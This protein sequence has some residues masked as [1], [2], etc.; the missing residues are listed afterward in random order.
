MADITKCVAYQVEKSGIITMLGYVAL[1]YACLVDLF[2]FHDMLN[3]L[4]WIG[5]SVIML[6]TILLTTHL[7]RN[8][9]EAKRE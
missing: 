2:I 5:L 3:W 1:V 8:K 6:T 7:I 4:E 9:N